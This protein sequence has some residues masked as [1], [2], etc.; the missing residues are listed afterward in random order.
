MLCMQIDATLGSI[1]FSDWMFKKVWLVKCARL[2]VQ[3][4]DKNRLVE[5]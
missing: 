1:E 2:P 3:Q 5:Y 4:I